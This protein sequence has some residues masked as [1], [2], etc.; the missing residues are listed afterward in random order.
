MSLDFEP[1]TAASAMSPAYKSV[2]VVKATGLA[3]GLFKIYVWM[4]V[5]GGL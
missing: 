2:W 4:Y 5:N 3:G 1:H